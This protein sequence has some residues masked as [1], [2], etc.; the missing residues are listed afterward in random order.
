[1]KKKEKK[2][3]GIPARTRRRILA[4]CM[5]FFFSLQIFQ[6]RMLWRESAEE[7]R[8]K[9]LSG[10]VPAEEN[11]R[12]QIMETTRQK[13]PVSDEQTAQEKENREQ[14]REQLL[15]RLYARSA[16]LV[17]ADNGRVL[18]GK[19]EHVMRPMASTT[20]IMTCILALERGNPKNLVTV[21]ANAAAQPEVHLGMREGEQ[22]YLEDLL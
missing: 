20:K 3:N 9:V 6:G 19:E 5:V 17:D 18:L 10:E 8:G 15:T 7:S 4:A 13:N 12:T 22:F 16:A 1:M 21:S 11:E 14:E 2:R